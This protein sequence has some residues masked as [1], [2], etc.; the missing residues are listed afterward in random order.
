[1]TMS[2]MAE[3]DPGLVLAAWLT[4]LA[5]GG[6]CIGMC[7]GI[8]G[9]FGVRQGTTRSGLSRLMAAQLGRISSYTLAGATVGF[10]GSAIVVGLFG[11]NGMLLLRFA[12]ALLIL[13]IGVQLLLGRP[14]LGWL[15][16]GGSR[17][18]RLIVRRCRFQLPPRRMLGAFGFGALWGWLPCG[19]VYA[20]LSVAALSGGPVSGAVVMAFF[21][22]G[23]CVSLSL[24]GLLL[25][26]MGLARLPRQ[27][28]GALL[29]LFAAWTIV[30]LLQTTAHMH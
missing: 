21:G 14:L 5:G 2:A 1:M 29:V 24:L 3:L 16:R 4:G 23:T 6:H 17:F 27:V 25:Q 26:S 22:L 15:E 18:W 7:G 12:A 13:T 10:L 8:A 28:S 11:P 19:L 30:P 20:E 9:A